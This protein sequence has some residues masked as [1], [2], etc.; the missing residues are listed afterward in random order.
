MTPSDFLKFEQERRYA[1]LV[2]LAIEGTATV[3]DEVIDLHDRIVGKLFNA[4]KH[5]H[6]EQFQTDGRAI[7][8][9]LRL[10]GRV[11]QALLEAKQKGGNAF[12]AIEAILSWEDF[13]AS[14]TEAQ[15]LAML[16]RRMFTLRRVRLAIRRRGRCPRWTRLW[17]VFR[18]TF[19]D[20][21]LEYRRTR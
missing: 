18:H 12:A 9:K 5:K 14:V 2:A 8:D 19:S 7:N 1:T 11:G 4:A 3:T 6:Q 21:L 10:Y 20:E 17:R 15:K 16:V 13:A